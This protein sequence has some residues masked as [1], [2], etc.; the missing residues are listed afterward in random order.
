MAVNRRVAWK[1]RN[2]QNPVKILCWDKLEKR[3]S[4]FYLMANGSHHPA[5]ST[6]AATTPLEKVTKREEWSV[7]LKIV[8]RIWYVSDG[9][10]VRPRVGLPCPCWA[11]LLSHFPT[12]PS[13]VQLTQ[14]EETTAEDALHSVIVHEQQKNEHGNAWL[15]LRAPAISFPLTADQV[16]FWQLVWTPQMAAVVFK[17]RASEIYL[18][19][20]IFF[21]YW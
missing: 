2:K 8:V 7:R 11:L 16:S 3:T 13:H 17:G 5:I 10:S 20:L 14:P 21:L 1:T 9:W 18:D 15:P 19:L 6:Y 4:L 12:S